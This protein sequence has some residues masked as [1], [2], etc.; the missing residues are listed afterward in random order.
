MRYVLLIISFPLTIG[1]GAFCWLANIV[2]SV[3][4]KMAAFLG[5]MYCLGF[6]TF[7]IVN[8]IVPQ[9]NWAQAIGLAGLVGMFVVLMRHF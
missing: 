8:S 5:L 3:D 7:S 4:S 1:I 6:L 9:S 2:V